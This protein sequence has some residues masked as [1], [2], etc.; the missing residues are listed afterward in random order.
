MTVKIKRADVDRVLDELLTEFGEDYVYPRTFRKSIDDLANG[1]KYVKGGAASCL[2]GHV[3][4]RLGVPIYNLETLDKA[5]VDLDD[6]DVLEDLGITIADSDTAMY[7][8]VMQSDQDNGTPW[9]KAVARARVTYPG[10]S[11]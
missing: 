4:N 7:L 1:C 11:E 8:T 6:T 2:V 5:A 9:G 10:G 3:F